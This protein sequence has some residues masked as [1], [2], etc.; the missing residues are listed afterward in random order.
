MAGAEERSHNPLLQGRRLG[1]RD[2]GMDLE[3]CRRSSLGRELPVF[4]D[5]RE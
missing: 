3:V 1:F 5:S 4:S 2:D